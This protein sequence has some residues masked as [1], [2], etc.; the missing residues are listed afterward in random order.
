MKSIAS[1][2]L[3]LVLLICLCEGQIVVRKS[4]LNSELI[5]SQD[6]SVNVQIYNTG[7][8]AIYSIT[9]DDDEYP[10][11]DW[12]IVAGL[13]SA[14][15]ERLAAG[16]NIS[17]TY[18]VRP[19]LDKNSER[20][21]FFQSAI[22]SYR[23]TPRGTELVSR[24]TPVYNARIMGKSDSERRTAPHLKEWGIFVILSLIVVGAPF[25]IWGF[26]V[27]AYDQGVLRKPTKKQA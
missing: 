12:D 14:K 18:V 11:S 17:H 20:P 3:G 6:V 1:V 16:A 15:W 24:S 9:L 5:Y 23:E 4:V 19:K 25:G 22:V 10:E 2:I 13:T 8:G 21:P 7:K 27:T 26:Y